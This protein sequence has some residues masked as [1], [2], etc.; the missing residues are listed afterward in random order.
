MSDFL[1]KTD[2]LIL[3]TISIVIIFIPA[4]I[5]QS[6]AIKYNWKFFTKSHFKNSA[7]FRWLIAGLML[8]SGTILIFFSKYIS[9]SKSN[10]LLIPLLCVLILPITSVLVAYFLTIYIEKRFKNKQ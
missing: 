6:L 1:Y 7:L 10:E 2:P 9:Y 5:L 3:M 4:Y 8:I